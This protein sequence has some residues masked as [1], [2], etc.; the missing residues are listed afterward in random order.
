MVFGKVE[1]DVA[2]LDKTPISSQFKR[3]VNASQYSQEGGSQ[4]KKQSCYEPTCG[5]VLYS[6]HQGYYGDNDEVLWVQIN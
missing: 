3:K 6:Q 5:A 1:V 4:K 2:L